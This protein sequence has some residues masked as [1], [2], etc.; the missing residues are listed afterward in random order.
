MV[1][2][3]PGNPS[4][5]LSWLEEK[6]KEV[7]PTRPFEFFFLDERIQ[8]Q[9]AREQQ[10]ARVTGFF[11]IITILISCFGLFGLASYTTERR[12]K[13][14]G[15]RKVLGASVSSLILLISREFLLLVL[16]ANVLAIP[17]VWILMGRWLED[18]AFRIHIEPTILITSLF[19]T[20]LIA[21]ISIATQ[22]IRAATRNP[23]DSLRYE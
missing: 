10:L 13:S 7:D 17:L 14:I 11:S 8:R 9:Y 20:L 2:L 5:A 4:A 3:A 16:A 21:F 15:I 18:F 22:T 1:K 23:V 12:A 6:W 19:V